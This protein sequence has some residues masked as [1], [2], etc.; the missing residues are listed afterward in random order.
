MTIKMYG[1][2][3]CP[4]C[5][6]SKAL[7]VRTQTSFEWVDTDQDAAGKAHIRQLQGQEPRIPTI[8]FDD[9]SFLVEP[10]DEDLAAKLGV[11]LDPA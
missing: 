10:S 8:V 9:G 3:W 2:D 1:A 6:R 4:D 7:L 5:R 11:P